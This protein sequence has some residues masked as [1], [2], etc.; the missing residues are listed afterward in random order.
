MNVPLQLVQQAEV[1]VLIQPLSRH[2]EAVEQVAAEE[3]KGCHS[4]LHANLP[5]QPDPHLQR[6]RPVVVLAGREVQ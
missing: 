1:L 5:G 6:I 2:V 3:V 4:P